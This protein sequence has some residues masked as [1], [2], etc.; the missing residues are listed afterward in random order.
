MKHFAKQLT[1]DT[2]FGPQKSLIMLVQVLSI[3]WGA[4]NEE[5]EAECPYPT[6]KLWLFTHLLSSTPNLGPL[7]QIQ[8]P[9]YKSRNVYKPTGLTVSMV[10]GS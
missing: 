10:T 1:Y 5:L 3:L 6:P 4:K 7:P 9:V 2:L 8:C